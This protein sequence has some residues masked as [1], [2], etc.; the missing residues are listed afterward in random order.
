MRRGEE[1]EGGGSCSSP[2]GR[3]YEERRSARGRSDANIEEISERRG[4]REEVKRERRREVVFG[5]I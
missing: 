1:R 4:D 3:T 2:G 5:A